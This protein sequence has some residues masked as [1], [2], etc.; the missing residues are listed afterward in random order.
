[1]A[2]TGETVGER[3]AER[4][5]HGDGDAVAVGHQLV[6]ADDV[7]M[8]EAGEDLA[9]P[10]QAGQDRAVR[11]PRQ[12]LEG[13]GAPGGAQLAGQVHL[14]ARAGGDLLAELVAGQA[15]GP[16]SSHKAT[17]P[18]LSTLVYV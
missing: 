8:V 5:L 10:A 17:L 6:D 11:T 13:D 2:V 12:P 1:M 14:P 3:P 7:G 9:L 16:G 4:V 18:R 15:V